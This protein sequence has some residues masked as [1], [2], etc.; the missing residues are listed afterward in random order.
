MESSTRIADKV[1][2]ALKALGRGTRQAHRPSVQADFG[3]YT[4]D[5]R[6]VVKDFKARLKEADGEFVHDLG[7]KLLR[8]NV[9]ECRQVAYELISAHKGAR[10]LLDQGRVEALGQGIDNWACVDNYCSYVAGR[11]WREG[12]IADSVVEN[13][14]R[15]P[16]L[17]WRR[18]AVVCTVALNTKSK[19]G[20]GDTTRTLRICEALAGD[21]EIMVQ[22]AISWAIRELV[23]WDR[24]AVEGFLEN[25]G[26]RVS[27]L[28]KREVE[29]KLRTGKKN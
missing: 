27:K 16:D 29:R 20:K 23:P 18:A 26:D 9:T 3:V 14:I 15:S 22:K 2:T 6:S 5:L 21:Q 8:K 24:E 25:H 17:W 11:A 7:L 19:G 28:V 4:A 1:T 10:E 13:W 12:R